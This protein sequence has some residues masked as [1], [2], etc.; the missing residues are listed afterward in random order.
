MN[1]IWSLIRTTLTG[2]IVFLIPLVLFI[3]IL[4]KAFTL[5]KLVVDPIIRL[6]PSDMVFGFPMH[7]ILGVTLLIVISLLAGYF[8]KTRVAM[9]ISNS[10]EDKILSKLPGYSFYKR[11]G[12]SLIGINLNDSHQVV[13]IRLDDA[14]QIAFLMEKLDNG[15]SAVFVPDAPDPFGGSLLFITNDRIEETDI[16]PASAYKILKRMGAGSGKLFKNKL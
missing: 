5:T 13:W 10:L 14:R 12:E 16:S 9:T 1:K 11:M 4:Q 8:S 7:R 3:L 2:G 15:T 6:L